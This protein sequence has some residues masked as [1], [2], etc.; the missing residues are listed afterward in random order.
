[1]WKTRHSNTLYRAE[2]CPAGPSAA[3]PALRRLP[4]LIPQGCGSAWRKL[5]NG[6]QHSSLPGLTHLS[7]SSV[8]VML[9]AP[10]ACEPRVTQ[11]SR[12]CHLRPC[13]AVG[14]RD[15]SELLVQRAG[16]AILYCLQGHIILN[17]CFLSPGNHLPASPW[18]SH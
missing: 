3:L 5:L 14:R 4:S 9:R 6:H 15:S 11:A 16:R 18:T 2:R 8:W 1:M 10:G 7:V 13:H 17:Y 12:W